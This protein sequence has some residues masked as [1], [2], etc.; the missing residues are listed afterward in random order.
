MTEE[1]PKYL[2]G[3]QKRKMMA[4]FRCKNEER[5]SK[6]WMEGEERRRKERNIE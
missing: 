4:R 5:E 3:E 1:I 2:W 6:Y